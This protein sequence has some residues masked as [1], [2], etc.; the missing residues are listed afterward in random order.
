MTQI[1]KFDDLNDRF[2]SLGNGRTSLRTAGGLYENS[3]LHSINIGIVHRDII[4]MIYIQ[5]IIL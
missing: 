3:M 4:S 1:N 5:N 2:T